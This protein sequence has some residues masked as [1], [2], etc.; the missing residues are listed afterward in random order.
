MIVRDD[1]VRLKCELLSNGIQ[2]G[3]DVIEYFRAQGLRLPIRVRSGSSEGL[4]L[5]IDGMA[6]NV[7]LGGQYASH[8]S[9]RL[10]VDAG[11]LLVCWGSECW[12]ATG[13]PLPATDGGR[14]TS[15][16]AMGG[17]GH[18]CFDRLGVVAVRECAFWSDP[19]KRCRFCG[20]GVNLG[21]EAESRSDEDVLEVARLAVTDEGY[22]A[23][24]IL[25]TGGTPADIDGDA[26]PRIAGLARTLRPLG[27]PIEAML[28]AP[29]ESESLEMMAEAGVSGVAINIEVFDSG[30]ARRL[31]P[32]K[33]EL[34]I[35]RYLRALEHAVR[36]FGRGNV[37]SLLVAGTETLQ[38]TVEGVQ[39]IA[40]IGARPVLS[41]YRMTPGADSGLRR[42]NASTLREL[43]ELSRD[44]AI[45]EGV[46]L[47]PVCTDC[48]CNILA[49]PWDAA[50]SPVQTRLGCQSLE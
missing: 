46:G 8:S 4:E 22:P 47:G 23:R 30:S 28:S 17:V 9:V 21:K 38:S 13:V 24:H 27:V 11:V 6:V 40:A 37:R 5:H 20:Y 44:V 19:G 49:F 18:H 33:H 14:T 26:V 3:P 12:R 43:Y 42:P 34:G 36:V 31:I 16:L 1:L 7:P 15:G 2:C 25:L 50:P 48:Q 35:A 45:D 10:Q 39:A 32:G 29:Q 41:P